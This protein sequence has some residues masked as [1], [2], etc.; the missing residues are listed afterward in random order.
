MDFGRH[1]KGLIKLSKL[2]L[3][4]LLVN[5][6]LIAFLMKIFILAISLIKLMLQ[7]VIVLQTSAAV[8]FGPQLRE[9]NF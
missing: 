9:G 6:E 5:L 4:L 3:E 8:A 1:L 7:L 2:L